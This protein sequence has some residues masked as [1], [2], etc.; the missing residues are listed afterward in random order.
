[1]V[2]FGSQFERNQAC[3]VCSHVFFLDEA[4]IEIAHDEDGV[5][6]VFCS[7]SDHDA[8]GAI[9][10]GLGELAPKLMEFADLDLPPAHYAQRTGADWTV[11][12]HPDSVN[13]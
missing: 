13:L 1:M 12:P 6:Q 7:R 5:I 10:V 9:V 2:L 3:I 11:R 8:R 4:I